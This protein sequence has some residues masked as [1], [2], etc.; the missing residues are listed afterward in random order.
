MNIVHA[1]LSEIGG[2]GRVALKDSE[3]SMERRALPS[4]AAHSVSRRV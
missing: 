1:M 2:W 3:V 4:N